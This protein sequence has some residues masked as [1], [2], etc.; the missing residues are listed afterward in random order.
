M[1]AETVCTVLNAHMNRNT[2][3]YK[4]LVWKNWTERNRSYMDWT[5]TGSSSNQKRLAKMILRA[6]LKAL[7]WFQNTS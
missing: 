6:H 3:T 5:V 1:I 2:V 7:W 4:H